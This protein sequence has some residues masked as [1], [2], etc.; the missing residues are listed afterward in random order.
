MAWVEDFKR[1]VA[2]ALS[3]LVLIGW[4]LAGF[5]FHQA[6]RIQTEA[7]VSLR[8]AEKARETLAADLQNLQRAA[9]VASDLRIQA[10]E[11]EKA[12][13]EASTARASAQN[14]LSD[15][16]KQINEAKLA[17]SGAQEEASARARDL[18]SVDA[19]LTEGTERLAAL[20]SQ[21]AAVLKQL[22]ALRSQIAAA[23]AE[24]SGY[25]QQIRDARSGGAQPH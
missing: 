16:T 17:V 7:A 22:E 11:A 21:E 20:Q 1:P 5:L 9:G 8:A 3:L 23:S 19:R 4:A 14:E 2:I 25:Q 18:Q 15:M 13:S 24:L 12:L 10:A 6:S